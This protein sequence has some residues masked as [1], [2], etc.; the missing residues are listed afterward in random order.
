MKIEEKIAAICQAFRIQGS[1]DGYEE[2][3]NG[4]VNRTY[5]VFFTNPDG[6][7]KTYILQKV[8]TYAFRNPIQLMENIDNVTEYIHAKCPGKTALHFH[9]TA[10]V[11]REDRKT[12]L[13]DE[14]GSFWRL[15]NYI[16]S[17]TYNTADD[18]DVVRSAG[19]AF[20]E[21]QTVLADFDASKLHYTIP[22]F[23]NTKKRYE[24]LF[25]DAENDTAG[26][27][28]KVAEEL[29]FLR[30][31][32]DQAC[33]LTEMQDAGELPLR[34]THND[35]KINNVLFD[36]TTHEALVV[37][38]LDTV[39]PGLIGHDFGDAVR[40]AANT[41]GE[42]CEDTAKIHVNM[43]VFG[44]FADGFLS[45]TAKT[46]T[47]NEV[48]TLALSAFVLAV[49]LATRFLDD[50]INGDK[51][52]KISFPEHNLVRARCQIALA[53][54]MLKHMDE[55]DALVKKSVARYQ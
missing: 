23:H 20:G 18:L 17:D 29:S 2:I 9:H 55:M 3:K 41:D 54:D 24:T 38:D 6:T 52:F 53:K 1:F 34:V 48:D 7:K 12:Y 31:V 25:A 27:V 32:K 30:S 51:Y 13:F 37:I 42:D 11:G 39:M 22:D 49:E 47:E 43:D 15:F 21:F 46:L 44:A 14:D 16:E 4:N 50:Y 10:E 28:G 35:T 8:N 40:Y 5:R 19:R 33:R 26:R 36:K 45:K